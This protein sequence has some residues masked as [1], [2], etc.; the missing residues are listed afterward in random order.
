MKGTNLAQGFC[1]ATKK[2]IRA[3][4]KFAVSE[5]KKRSFLCGNPVFEIFGVFYAFFTSFLKNR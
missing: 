5:Q 1:N 4:D 2:S 3:A